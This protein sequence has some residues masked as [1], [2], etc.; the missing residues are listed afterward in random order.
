MAKC[1]ASRCEVTS[2]KKLRSDGFCDKHKN[3]APL[4]AIESDLT[5]VQRVAD[6]EAENAAMKT[7]LKAALQAIDNIHA[8][9]NSQGSSINT[10][11]YERDALEQ[12]GR[13]ESER[14][15]D[16]DEEPLKLDTN[17]NIIDN[18]DCVQLA[19]EAAAVLDV[20]LV[21]EDIQRAHRVGR[22]KKPSVDKD[23]RM[24]TPKPRQIIVK[25]KDYGK[26]QS[27]IKNKRKFK[28]NAEIKNA[29][30]FKNGFI[31]EDLTPLRS[32]L[33]WYAKHQ[34]N[35]K[36]KNCHTKN[37]QILAQT[38]ESDKWVDLSTPDHFHKHGIDVDIDIINKGLRKMQILKEGK[39]QNVSHLLQ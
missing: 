1:K 24:F 15:V 35:D 16:V 2:L 33:L 8:H 18:E 5:L 17:G 32:K 21:K 39:F 34:C 31:V 22:R 3:L 29:K 6:L 37:G 28:E 4:P 13:R 26:R 27:M 25:L 10:A 7:A 20:T 23:G 36:F 9:M 14:L 30:K 11:N 38:S 19:I 12:Y